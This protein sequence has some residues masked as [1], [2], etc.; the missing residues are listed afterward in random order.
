MY[1]SLLPVDGALIPFRAPAYSCK[2]AAPRKVGVAR[3]RDRPANRQFNILSSSSIK[4]P[5]FRI[6]S[7]KSGR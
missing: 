7:E 1:N 5:I 2:A 3:S 6:L 4:W